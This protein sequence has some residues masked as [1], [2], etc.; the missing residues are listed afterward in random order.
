MSLEERVDLLERRFRE[1]E[2]IIRR[3]EPGLSRRTT[4]ASAARVED[5]P[6]PVSTG[7]APAPSIPA[8]GL[9]V[10]PPSPPPNVPAASVPSVDA[11]TIGTEEWVGQRGLLAVGVALMVLGAGYLVKL[12]IDREWISAS[13][14]CVTGAVLGF[15]LAATG[16]RLFP[17][18]RTYGAALIGC[19]AAV[20][21]VAT[22]A[23]TRMYG[24]LPAVPGLAILS[25]VSLGVF[26]IA[27]VV[28]VEAL[29]AAAAL[30]AFLAPAML[31]TRGNPDALLLYSAC[32][33]AGLGWVAEK[34][35]RLT[36]ALIGLCFFVIGGAAATGATA[37]GVLMYAVLGA[38]A[39]LAIGLREGWGELRLLS[40][41]GGWALLFASID[42]S[43]DHR[44]V[45]AG[46]IILA[47]PVWWRALRR[48][49]VV[50]PSLAATAAES[51]YFYLTA[52]LLARGLEQFAPQWFGDHQWARWLVLAVPY[53]AAGYWKIRV[54]FAAVGAV[55]LMLAALEAWEGVGA[56]WALLGLALVWAGL[57]HM[58]QR[59]DGRWYAVVAIGIG[60]AHLVTWDLPHRGTGPA[61]GDPAAMA[62]WATIVVTAVLAAGGWRDVEL[63]PDDVPI[64]T[65]ALARLAAIGNHILW[66][67]AGA[68]L[69][70]AVTEELIRFFHQG[71]VPVG[72]SAELASGL[73]VSAWWAAFAAGLVVLGFWQADKSTRLAGL[74]VSG[75]AVGKVVL[76]DLAR[77]DALY[78]VASVLTLGLVS[79]G[80]AFLYHRYARLREPGTGNG[81]RAGGA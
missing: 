81:E 12:A 3:L 6:R 7:T 26:V 4:I 45:A 9:A 37:A 8:D 48:V 17:R 10:D 14:R 80:V 2:D 54:P 36:T 77:L 28:G 50:P 29:A 24:L 68:M 1:L 75:L 27:A 69:F 40:F 39:G 44:L 66:I 56:V 79:L 42:R 53:L 65:G 23:A 60:I 67:A 58:Q 16:W 11:P 51:L 46:A 41:A 59:A 63:L 21:Y 19:G 34:R 73:S 52:W 57:D 49:G 55:A 35:W 32:L 15:V 43:A 72:V 74:L 25:L 5:R 78:R 61:F 30:G 38:S 18:F 13:I 62:V 33:A 71:P 64:W 31:G 70:V 76:V 20:V 47:A 22:W